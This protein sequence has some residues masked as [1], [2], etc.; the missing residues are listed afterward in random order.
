MGTAS[1]RPG[2]YW[3]AGN[4]QASE[5]GHVFVIA[6]WGDLRPLLPQELLALVDLAQGWQF[7]DWWGDFHLTRPLGQNEQAWRMIVAFQT[8]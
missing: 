6:S 4:Q 5:L 3:I 1:A 2:G 7:A 8:Q